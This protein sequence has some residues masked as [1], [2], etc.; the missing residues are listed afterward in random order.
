MCSWT[1]GIYYSSS[2]SKTL[3]ILIEVFEEI[4]TCYVG[5]MIGQLQGSTVAQ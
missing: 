4:G 5:D 1:P 2:Q 3:E